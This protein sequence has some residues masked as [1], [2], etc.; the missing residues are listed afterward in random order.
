[1]KAEL[2]KYRALVAAFT[3]AAAVITPV[4]TASGAQAYA[5]CGRTASDRDGGSWRATASGAHMRSGSSTGCSSNG[6]AYSGD[7]LD[8]HCYTWGAPDSQG[9]TW[10]WTYARN[11]RTG[12]QGWLRSDVLSDERSSVYCG[13]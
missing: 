7:A 6:L 3:L 12:V 13:F 4:A 10:A 2:S 9:F 5:N 11:T 1:M 8:Y